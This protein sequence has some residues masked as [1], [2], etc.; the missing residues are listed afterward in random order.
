[1]KFAS[2]RKL[3]YPIRAVILLLTLSLLLTGC[4][5]HPLEPPYPLESFEEKA[6]YYQFTWGDDGQ[7]GAVKADTNVF[8]VGD[9]TLSFHFGIRDEKHTREAY[10]NKLG[11]GYYERVEM[12]F[13]I[14]DKEFVEHYYLLEQLSVTDERLKSCFCESSGHVSERKHN[15][16]WFSFTVPE[17]LFLQRKTIHWE[18][19]GITKKEGEETKEIISSIFFSYRIANDKI[20]IISDGCV[21]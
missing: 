19:Y 2:K 20:Y 11:N 5:D 1:M 13:V 18:V 7:C 12:Y 6:L 3:F 17:E 14:T 8:D 21:S 9:V 10:L 16:V 15:D 4:E